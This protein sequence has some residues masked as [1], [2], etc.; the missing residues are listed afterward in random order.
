MAILREYLAGLLMHPVMEKRWNP[1]R[2]NSKNSLI[3]RH[4][5]KSELQTV[6]KLIWKHCKIKDRV[7]SKV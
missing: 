3:R 1:L 6:L 5:A 4:Q 2:A 7:K